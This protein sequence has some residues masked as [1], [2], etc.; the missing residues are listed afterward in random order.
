[1][2][3]K[4]IICA[5]DMT[6]L[7]VSLN[8][9]HLPLLHVCMHHHTRSCTHAQDIPTHPPTVTFDYVNLGTREVYTTGS[10]IRVHR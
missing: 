6:C 4:Y 9:G 3:E 2:Y 7:P 10:E 1:M 8:M 5:M